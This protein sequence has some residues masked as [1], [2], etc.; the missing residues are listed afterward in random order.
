MPDMLTLRHLGPAQVDQAYPIVQSMCPDLDVEAWRLFAKSI[1]EH[2]E[3]QAGIMT[4][5]YQGYIHG[6]FSYCVEPHLVHQR[7]LLVDNVM[8]VDL[9]N[10]RAV[11][12][13]LLRAMDE[14]AD[15]LGCRA[16]HSF[17]PRNAHRAEGQPHWLVERFCS[18]GHH[19][20][21][22]A[23]CKRLPER[24]HGTE[25]GDANGASAPESA[26]TGLRL[27]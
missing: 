25:R 7:V 22:A 4:V 5:Q 24:G 3:D 26:L 18:H 9:F 23:L 13:A 16:I 21:S 6:L 10:P 12:D 14:L 15:R 19:L 27:R 17:L 11:A 20:E 1:G 2:A 8:V